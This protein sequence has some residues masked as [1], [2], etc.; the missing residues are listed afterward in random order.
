MCA[1]NQH[2]TDFLFLNA[3]SRG[4]T[5]TRRADRIKT[6]KIFSESQGL[7]YIV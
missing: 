6:F 3:C 1:H 4:E 7:L 5:F 2:L